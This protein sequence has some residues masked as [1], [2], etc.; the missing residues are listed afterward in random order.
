MV[1]NGGACL[2]KDDKTKDTDKSTNF[3]DR[4]E[5]GIVRCEEHVKLNRLPYL[6]SANDQDPR[7]T[8]GLR[9]FRASA[10]IRP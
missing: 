9:P 10:D 1:R 7:T 4:P 8:S 6:C 2:V 5:K 3:A